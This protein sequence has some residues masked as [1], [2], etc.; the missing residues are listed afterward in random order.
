[1]TIQDWGAI[2]GDSGRHAVFLTLVFLSVQIIQ[3][4][5]LIRAQLRADRAGKRRLR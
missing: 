5:R 3:T 2:G 1:M 4:K